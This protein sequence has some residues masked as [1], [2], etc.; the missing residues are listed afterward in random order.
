MATAIFPAAGQGKRMGA[1]RNKVLLPLQGE[2]ILTHTLLNFSN[3]KEIDDLIVVTAAEEIEEVR[4]I[5]VRTAGLKPWRVVAGGSERQYSVANGLAAL[6]PE[7][8][9]VLVH[10]AARPFVSAGTIA[11][12]IGQARLSGAAIAA[13]PEKNTIKIVNKTHVVTATPAR[14]TLWSVQTPQGFRR[15]IILAAYARAAAEGFL[16]TDD[17]GLVERMGVPVKV[18]PSDYRNIKITTPED[19][20]I[21]E[22]FLK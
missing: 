12:V 4:G 5:L 21:A 2:L 22:A 19:M 6:R 3:N 20:L 11:A 14:E 8:E 9:I 13:V 18:V 1:G 15:E 17:A 7:S 10:D 16:G